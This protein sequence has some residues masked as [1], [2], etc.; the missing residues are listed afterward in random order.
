LPAA[1]GAQRPD[2]RPDPEVTV[3]DD[4]ANFGTPDPTERATGGYAST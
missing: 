3:P 1:C 2:W 4:P